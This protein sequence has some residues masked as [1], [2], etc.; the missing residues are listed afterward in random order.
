MK[1]ADG[2]LLVSALAVLL[3]AG[4]ATVKMENVSPDRPVPDAPAFH[5]IQGTVLVSSDGKTHMDV[6]NA[7]RNQNVFSRVVTEPAS[8]VK[9]DLELVVS[10]TDESSGHFCPELFLAV[11]RGV[12]FGLADEA[13]TDEYD[14]TLTL[15]ATLTRE[16][17]TVGEYEAVG[18][19]HAECPESHPVA[20]R[21]GQ[22]SE[23][24]LKSWQHA[25]AVLCARIKQDRD[26][27]QAA[28]GR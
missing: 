28:L 8:G 17:Q 22:A 15:K 5:T 23:A 11:L 7:L 27:I 14:Y 10:H 4:C 12:M 9:P 26:K 2:H 25:L 13:F 24:V 1:R 18:S 21:V 16:G 6:A 19:F 3:A 20:S